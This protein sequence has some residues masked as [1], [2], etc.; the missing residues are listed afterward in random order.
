MIIYCTGTLTNQGK[1]NMSQRGA[2]AK[3]ENV[4][5]WNNN[6]KKEFEY[7]PQ[8]GAK[9][10]NS[11]ATSTNTYQNV[12][13]SITN[14]KGI[15]R[16]T[17]GGASGGAGKIGSGFAARGGIGGQGTSYSGGRRSEEV[18]QLK[19]LFMNLKMQVIILEEKR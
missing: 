18:P 15:G 16:Q 8:Y 11:N 19:I 4:Y 1:I 10:A 2:Y 3:G 17:A 12:Y 7:V 5:L 14:A 13:P 9:G 6:G